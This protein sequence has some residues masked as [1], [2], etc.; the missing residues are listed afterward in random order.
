[1]E[2]RRKG[3][4]QP[5]RW[6]GVAILSTLSFID[7]VLDNQLTRELDATA[8]SGTRGGALDHNWRINEMR[9]A[10]KEPFEYIRW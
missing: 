2:K 9:I 5:D 4:R 7:N 10:I 3:R 8:R 1:M 6:A